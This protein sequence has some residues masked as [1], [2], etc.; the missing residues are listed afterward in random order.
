MNKI[1]SQKGQALILIAL[2]VVGLVGFSALAIDGGRVFSDKRHAQSAAD[3]A[4]FAAA[5]AKIRGG[6]YVAAAQTRAISNG[7]DDA[8]AN[9]IVEVHLC[10]EAGIVC[11]GLPAGAIPAEYVQVKITSYVPT[12]FARVIGR[13]QMENVVEAVARASTGTSGATGGG[14]GYG[15]TALKQGC[16]GGAA[17]SFTGSGD[18]SI[19][20]GIG[21]NGCFSNTGSGDFDITGNVEISYNLD[22]SGSANWNVGG[23]VWLNGYSKTGSGSW[24]VAGSFFD[25]ANFYTAGSAQYTFGSFTTVGSYAKYGSAAVNIWPPATGAPTP[26]PV[27]ADP[28][29]SVLNPPAIPGGSCPTISYSGSTDHTLSP[30]CYTSISQ[31]GSGD[32]TLDPGVYYI[33]TGGINSSGSGN[34]TAH[35]VMIY[36]KQGAF[37]MNGSGDFDITPI[38]SGPYTGLSIY[39]DRNNT[40]SYSMTGSGDSSFT[41][42]VY[43]PAA[44]VSITG[45]TGTMVVDSQII[46]YTTTLIGSG[47]LNLVYTPS[48]NYNPFPA[49][50]PAIELVD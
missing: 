10:N 4:A 36:L 11:E 28:Y 13:T 26:P 35:G 40:S 22:D 19:Q 8:S 45:S 16:S 31:S 7:Y 5:L 44:S 39:M 23:N 43:A 2:A 12:T 50:Q 3:T 1:K 21:D 9:A 48:N 47:D 27:I 20:G 38:T 6:D 14:S 37:G 18:R 46:S 17:I 30:G 24:D 33:S 49:D 42:T 32:L 15:I 25:N 29:A 41:G 34:I